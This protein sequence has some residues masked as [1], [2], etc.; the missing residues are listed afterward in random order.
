MAAFNTAHELMA[1]AQTFGCTFIGPPPWEGHA[2]LAIQL[3][4]EMGNGAPGF[5]NVFLRDPPWGEEAVYQ[6]AV[7]VDSLRP[8]CAH[9]VEPLLPYGPHRAKCPVCWLTLERLS[10]T[11]S[12][13]LAPFYAPARR[14]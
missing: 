7:L 8:A 5:L 9:D 2:A 13:Q 11:W 4:T 3:M 1:R 10:G 12:G 14:R 6:L